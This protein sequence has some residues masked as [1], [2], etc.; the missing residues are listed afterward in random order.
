MTVLLSILCKSKC[1][2][3]LHTICCL[4][5]YL[6]ILV[7]TLIAIVCFLVL[8][9]HGAGF[10]ICPRLSASVTSLVVEPATE[11]LVRLQRRWSEVFS[12][13]LSL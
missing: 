2:M 6:N 9:I 7:T 5:I 1:E 4:F 11:D 12:C 13:R 8:F 10:A 3:W